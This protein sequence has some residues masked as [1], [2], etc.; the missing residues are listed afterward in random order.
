VFDRIVYRKIRAAFGGSLRFAFSGASP[1]GERLTYFFDGVGIR[2]F[3]GYGLT[4]T[5]PV[6]TVNRAD[7]WVPGTVG[8]PVCGTRVRI[9]ADGEILAA[10]PQVFT[11]YWANEEGTA[12]ALTP[13]GW[14]RTGDLGELA[15]GFL[16]ITGRKKDI[17]VTAGGKNV[18][19]APMEDELRAHA[20]IDQAVVIGDNRPFVAAL[21]TLDPEGFDRWRSARGEPARTVSESVDHPVLRAAI[22][23]AVDRVNAT[24]SRAESIRAFAILPTELTEAAGEITPTLKVRRAVVEERYADIIDRIYAQ[25]NPRAST[26][27][28]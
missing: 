20:L 19:P 12:A 14:L 13:D 21:V 8:P 10:G 9:A 4:E 5:S 24:R 17:I 22:Q 25:P 26:E 28:R 2:I 15:G 3:E 6:L 1:L 23:V 11:G 16:H 7:A 18:A 27:G